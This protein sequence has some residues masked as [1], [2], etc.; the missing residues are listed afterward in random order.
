MNFST[1]E[2][3]HLSTKKCADYEELDKLICEKFDLKYTK[4]DYG[5]FPFLEGEMPQES[6]SWTGLI[7]E[8]V[9][10]SD[11]EYGTRRKSEVLGALVYV[12]KHAIHFPMLMIDVLS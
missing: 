10:W 2:I 4:E 5:H 3:R 9:Y 11:I 6:I 12:I 1:F 8:I 7:H